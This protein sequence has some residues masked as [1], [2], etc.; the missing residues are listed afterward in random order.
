MLKIE[1]IGKPPARAAPRTNDGVTYEN[2]RI[3]KVRDEVFPAP[4][5]LNPKT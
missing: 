1:V 5:T 3:G 4:R 2:E